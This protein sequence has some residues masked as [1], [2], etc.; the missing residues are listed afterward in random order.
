MDRW[1]SAVHLAEVSG[2]LAPSRQILAT[3]IAHDPVFPCGWGTYARWAMLEAL[4]VTPNVTIPGR[5]LSWV[6]VRASGPG[7]QNV[8]KVSTKVA[9]TFDLAGT[10]ALDPA[11]KARLRIAYPSYVDGRGLMTVTSQA[12][13]EQPR[14]LED[15]LEKLR[16]MIARALVVPK[17]RKKTRP[18]RGAKE[19]RLEAKHRH[20]EKKIG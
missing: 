3:W 10:V 20:G 15:A 5:D 1:R 12:T 18:S 7:G 9:L 6:A 19:R 17:R 8:N 4:V 14:N 16:E 11:T 13:R 2:V